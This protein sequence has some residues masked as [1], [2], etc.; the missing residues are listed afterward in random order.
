[1]AYEP[2][3]YDPRQHQSLQ[4]EYSS[5]KDELSASNTAYA[6]GTD[7][8]FSD[9]SGQ[10]KMQGL[11]KQ[12]DVL[13]GKKLA[14]KWYGPRVDEETFKGS[15]SQQSLLMR[16]L[17]ALS[18]PLYGV[19]G[20]AEAALGQG[21]KKGVLDNITAN[22]KE[23]EGFGNILRRTGLPYAASMPLG[24]ALDVALD[25]VNW[26]T[27]GTAAL[28]PRVGY[29]L[30]KGGVKGA[31]TGAVSRLAP[32]GV[33]TANVLSLGGITKAQK[34]AARVA[35]GGIVPKGLEKFSAMV[36][37]TS[38]NIAKAGSEAAQ[39]YDQIVGKGIFTSRS[40]VK[41]GKD[42]VRDGAGYS[43]GGERYSIGD[44]MK[45]YIEEQVPGGESFLKAMVYSPSNWLRLK[46]IESIVI[47]NS[48]KFKEVT[49]MEFLPKSAETS[50][51]V[52]ELGPAGVEK[53]VR[54]AL[55]VEP[56]VGIPE[57][58]FGES[59]VDSVSGIL[60]AKR[61]MNDGFNIATGKLPEE[62]TLSRGSAEI[63]RNLVGESM[64]DVTTD[65]VI[66]ILNKMHQKSRNI[67]GIEWYDKG[68][69]SLRNW[70]VADKKPVAAVLDG[71]SAFISAF[72]VSKIGLSAAAFT[73][74][75]VGNVTMIAMGGQNVGDPKLRKMAQEVAGIIWKGDG[76]EKR[77]IGKLFS[78]HPGIGKAWEEYALKN[79][80]GF[81]GTFQFSLGTVLEQSK[82]V[83]SGLSKI[84]KNSKK[85]GA[86]ANEL[87]K[88]ASDLVVENQLR[89][90]LTKIN[91]Q[92]PDLTEYAGYVKNEVDDANNAF[93]KMARGLQE[94][95]AAPGAGSGTK[96]ANFLANKPME[97][98]GDIDP[99]F[100]VTNALHLSVNGI[101]EAELKVM[102]RTFGIAKDDIFDV[103]IDSVTGE[104]KFMLTPDKATEIVGE[105]FL[106]YSAMPA[107]V[108]M[109]RTLP[110]L[111]APFAS[112]MYG[113]TTR[114][115]KTALYNP[116]IFNKIN[117]LLQ[118]FSGDKSPL[119]KEAMNSKYYSWF[120]DPG[121]VKIPWA[122]QYPMYA[123]LT[124]MIPYYSMN[125]FTPSE[126]KYNETLPDSV[127]SFLDKV[128]L[129][130]DPA[131]QV[132]FDYIIQP[133]LLSKGQQPQGAFG[134]ALYPTDA[135][136][137][138]KFG[139]GVRQMGEAVVPGAAGILGLATG[140]V[141]TGD[142]AK[143]V[144]SYRYRQL[145]NAMKGKTSL[146]IPSK[147]PAVARTMRAIGSIGGLNLQPMNTAFTEQE[148]KKKIKSK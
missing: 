13:E 141:T 14:E 125:M 24:F 79:P 27:A 83:E 38:K 56:G 30:M 126:R 115:A 34:T 128:P 58:I 136:A 51:A 61:T 7:P 3:K 98:F 69:D 114:T 44:T 59:E 10:A 54:E 119:E 68:I 31:T 129:L 95:A 28:I 130:Q 80:A 89:K 111:G 8:T 5:L 18:V 49:G 45:K 124:N 85:S 36:G 127:M 116:A 67:T 110:I 108:K 90:T 2:T 76:N 77:L 87:Q 142:H 143:Y 33:K 88:T 39:Q 120:K 147:E 12:I 47:K 23:R 21:S 102:G 22:I 113:M 65:D 74:A 48:N 123:N 42:L 66:D 25:P 78:D 26:V 144:P 29:G 91:P 105:T 94:K 16:G 40:G 106:N 43:I 139:Y 50:A 107:A 41:Y 75:I 57:N 17:N 37:G 32:L 92:R 137:L 100:R 70:K 62:V 64:S 122:D 15:G 6:P 101:T 35:G 117:F 109:L 148:T 97:W 93:T 19:A 121:M 133:M 20:V 71:Y 11:G 63:M 99:T 140:A 73:N 135:T 103:A 46:G 72:K 53:G 132:M 86:A 82:A 52:R 55:V 131:G 84:L 145:V 4:D 9:L 1:M 96:V 81:A 112:F 146:G 60:E 134:Q 118:E 104:R 138:D